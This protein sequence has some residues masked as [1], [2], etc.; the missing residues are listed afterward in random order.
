MDK[1]TIEAVQGVVD[2]WFGEAM[3][4][5]GPL[6]TTDAFNKFAAQ[7]EALKQKLAASLAQ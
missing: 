7:K 1:E 3:L 2:Q 4:Q 5:L 6:L